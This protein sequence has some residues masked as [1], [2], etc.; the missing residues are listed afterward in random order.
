MVKNKK[1]KRMTRLYIQLITLL[2]VISSCQ[3]SKGV[4]KDLTT[5]LSAS[6][7]GFAIEDIYLA[8]ETGSRLT[9]NAIKMGSKVLVVVT[10]VDYFSEKEGKVFPGCRIILTDKDKKELLHLPDAFSNMDEG[11]SSSDAKTLQGQLNTGDPMIVGETYHLSVRFYDKNK[12]DNEI[13]A[14]IDLKMKE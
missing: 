14:N 9:D 5:G 10:G 4:K 2:L 7:N 6:Y 8:D 13:V 11:I 12:K 3:F 1:H